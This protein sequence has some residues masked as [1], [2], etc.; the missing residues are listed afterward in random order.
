M[1]MVH[2]LI[3]G[4]GAVSQPRFYLRVS[5]DASCPLSRLC[6]PACTGLRTLL[7]SSS[8]SRKSELYHMC[9]CE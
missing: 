8:A 9:H 2:V 1:N 7:S 3:N 6:I 4:I 5:L